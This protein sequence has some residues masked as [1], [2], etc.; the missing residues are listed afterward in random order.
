MQNLGNTMKNEKLYYQLTQCLSK[1]DINLITI[2][3]SQIL[4]ESFNYGYPNLHLPDIVADI[5]FF[6]L[7]GWNSLSKQEI[8]RYIDKISKTKVNY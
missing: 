8:I 4:K 7:E 1:K 2:R 5:L 6:K 3:A